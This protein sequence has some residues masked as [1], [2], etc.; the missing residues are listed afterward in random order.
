M[1]SRHKKSLREM[2][3][4]GQQVLAPCAYDCL[5]AKALEIAGFDAILLSG[6]AMAYMYGVVD[7]ES[8]SLE[9]MARI[10]ENIANTVD[11]PIVVDGGD[12]HGSTTSAVNRN[13]RRLAQAGA[14]GVTIEDTDGWFSPEPLPFRGKG[15]VRTEKD[16]NRIMTPWAFGPCISDKIR[17]FRPVLE[18]KDFLEKIRA[19]VQAC[20]GTDCMVVTRVESYDVW[21]FDETVE[22]VKASM[23]LGAEM[24]TVCGGMWWES[25][26]RMFS[27]ALNGWAMWPDI[28]SHEGKAN[29]ELSTLNELGFNFVTFHI[30]EKAVMYGMEKFGKEIFETGSTAA[31]DN[32]SIDG[33]TPEQQRDVLSM[34]FR[35]IRELE[36]KLT[37]A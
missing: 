15:G 19:A 35:R 22:R 29:V 31:I 18:R 36:R 5:T 13:V 8:I 9:E 7:Q 25:D 34:D 27:E 37:R 28:T 12:G 26:A 3:A 6:G 11:I 1:E 21:G 4:S 30:A 24:W 16:L 2:L 17:G 32:A 33:L 10:T 14:A 23:D 20:E